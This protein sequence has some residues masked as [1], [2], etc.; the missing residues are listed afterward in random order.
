MWHSTSSELVTGHLLDHFLILMCFLVPLPGKK[1]QQE[2]IPAAPRLLRPVIEKFID[3]ELSSMRKT[4]AKRLTESKVSV[5]T[6]LRF[7]ARFRFLAP[8]TNKPGMEN[9]YNTGLSLGF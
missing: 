7:K 6:S 2:S 9:L 5:S 3:I 4:I 1:V 8:L